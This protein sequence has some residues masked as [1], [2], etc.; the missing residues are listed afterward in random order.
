MAP[1][2]LLVDSPE[3][4]ERVRA[5]NE[6]LRAENLRLR[7]AVCAARPDTPDPLLI[8]ST[9]AA[10]GTLGAADRLVHLMRE[11]GHLLKE[12]EALMAENEALESELEVLV[13]DA[14]AEGAPRLA[15]PEAPAQAEEE[16][17]GED[18][19]V[20]ERLVP[21][22]SEGD[23]L[24]TEREGLR[25]ERKELVHEL[26]A[27][28][29]KA[30]QEEAVL[31]DLSASD[32]ELEGRFL[33]AVEE[34]S[35]ENSNLEA[36]IKKLRE[37]NARLRSKNTSTIKATQVEATKTINTDTYSSIEPTKPVAMTVPSDEKPIVKPA[38]KP[39]RH[40]GKFTSG[41]KAP[42]VDETDI[43]MAFSQREAMASLLRK[44]QGISSPSTARSNLTARG[45]S[46][47]TSRAAQL[48]M[49][50]EEQLK[51]ALHTLFRNF[52][53]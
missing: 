25:A 8:C 38:P 48:D 49:G 44:S 37:E 3:E 27:M 23:A 12:R 28:G 15:I 32:Q 42:P 7:A 39:A 16:E 29:A 5:E 34:A 50:Q 13:Q 20:I 14:G 47:N 9:P 4:A 46:P 51:G 36:Q 10:I 21:L 26:E 41:F 53:R 40:L 17:G 52:G 19:L 45:L 33:C 2:G 30:A 24:R 1:S 6:Q 22:L 18:A 31:E 11:G 43:G 35:R